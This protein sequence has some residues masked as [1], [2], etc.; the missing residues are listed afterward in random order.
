MNEQPARAGVIARAIPFII[1]L[2]GI[3]LLLGGYLFHKRTVYLDV[4]EVREAPTPVTEDAGDEWSG[5]P[6][7]AQPAQEK[8]IVERSRLERESHLVLEITRGGV[9]RLASGK[10][11]RT[12]MGDEPP[13]LCPT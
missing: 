8:I 11:K 2:V 1:V 12:Y 7:L 4:E 5:T 13:A 6:G 3:G 9:T 10:I